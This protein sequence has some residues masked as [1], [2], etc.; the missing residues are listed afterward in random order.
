MPQLHI[1]NKAPGHTRFDACLAALQPGDSL[2][3]I[4]DAVIACIDI[5]AHWPE[6]VNIMAL[7]AD[8][9]A[10]GITAPASNISPADYDRWVKLTME[11]PSQ[12]W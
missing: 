3:L 9:R 12:S 11:L 8:L 7:E 1:I 10:R 4:E 2:L 5:Q 6:Q